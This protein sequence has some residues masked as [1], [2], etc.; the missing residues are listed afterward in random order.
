MA[1][2]KIKT[3]DIYIT[4]KNRE[5]EISVIKLFGMLYTHFYI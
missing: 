4:Y 3:S 5:N 2:I 1:K